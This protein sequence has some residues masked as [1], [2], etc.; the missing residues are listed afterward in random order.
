MNNLL[1][2][3][4]GMNM[5]VPTNDI[6]FTSVMACPLVLL[7]LKPVLRT[8]GCYSVFYNMPVLYNMFSCRSILV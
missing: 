1:F 4:Q 7:P 8:S 2:N 6:L 3:M 5:K